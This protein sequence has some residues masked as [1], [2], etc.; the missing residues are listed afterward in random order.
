MFA[1]QK[2]KQAAA[3]LLTK[4]NQSLGKLVGNLIL[5]RRTAEATALTSKN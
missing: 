3:V 5:Q 2:L 1:K 4:F